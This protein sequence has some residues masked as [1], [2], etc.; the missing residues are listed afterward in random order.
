MVEETRNI[1]PPLEHT[2]EY[3]HIEE[4]IV[5][6]QDDAQDDDWCN[7][8]GVD[9]MNS[10]QSHEQ[11]KL[12]RHLK[13]ISITLD[14]Y[15][16]GSITITE[17]CN[18]VKRKYSYYKCTI[19]EDMMNGKSHTRTVV[20]IY[21]F[22]LMFLSAVLT[23][24]SVHQMYKVLIKDK[25][26][27]LSIITAIIYIFV[28][29][30]VYSVFTNTTEYIIYLNENAASNLYSSNKSYDIT[31]IEVSLEKIIKN[32]LKSKPDVEKWCAVFDNGNAQ[33][34]KTTS[35]TSP[36]M[37][38]MNKTDALSN[39]FNNQRDFISKG[40]NQN[41]TIIQNASLDECYDFFT[42]V[43]TKNKLME[44]I[45]VTDEEESLVY[46]NTMNIRSNAVRILKY[47]EG[48]KFRKLFMTLK[49]SEESQFY[50]L[51][52]VETLN[53]TL[54]NFRTNQ[55]DSFMIVS[56]I[57][58]KLYKLGLPEYYY[59]RKFIFGENDSSMGGNEQYPILM[60]SRNKI[61]V[62]HAKDIKQISD[63]IVDH[64]TEK[65]TSD[66]TY[67]FTIED[68]YLLQNPLYLE[69]ESIILDKIVYVIN[70]LVTTRLPTDFRTK[71]LVSFDL[72]NE[73][74]IYY[75]EQIT[76]N[77]SLILNYFTEKIKSDRHISNDHKFIFIHNIKKVIQ[78]AYAESKTAPKNSPLFMSDSAQVAPNNKYISFEDFNVKLIHLNKTHINSF[79]KV[80]KTA[81]DDL[82]YYMNNILNIDQGDETTKKKDGIYDNY[83]YLFS[84]ISGLVLINSVFSIYCN[85]NSIES[86]YMNDNP[87][88]DM[89]KVCVDKTFTSMTQ[90]SIHVSIWIVIVVLLNTYSI[91]RKTYAQYNSITMRKNTE[92]LRRQLNI[93]SIVLSGYQTAFNEPVSMESSN[94]PSVGILHKKKRLYAEFVKL[95]E[96]YGKCN[97]I[98]TKLQTQ[99]FP[100]GNILTS[101]F[102]LGIMCAIIYVTVTNRPSSTSFSFKKQTGGA[103]AMKTSTAPTRFLKSQ[104]QVMFDNISLSFSIIIISLYFSFQVFGS[105]MKIQHSLNSGKLYLNSKCL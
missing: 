36:V 89:S 49:I 17:A 27:V 44:H 57:L 24:Y 55:F 47:I 23:M 6:T 61:E 4:E 84:I 5:V 12:I 79:L 85:G 100:T 71:Y 82:K 21:K 63:R 77:S 16:K 31:N 29:N 104:E 95:I 18:T 102:L 103:A 69:S 70:S 35:T 101:V 2:D 66:A 48:H 3:D 10:L 34:E 88:F 19:K 37:V 26:A 56:D 39:F 62:E 7:N 52:C 13:D 80:V 43:N 22:S 74:L 14:D 91:N 67:V 11:Q 51:Y 45:N 15:L 46:D 28:F 53:N 65:T 97:H 50:D 58:S 96:I 75:C 9:E 83:I 59:L 73:V 54:K 98:R 33:E 93:F 76:S 20:F 64:L 72:I 87:E 60:K 32:D 25:D 78:S 8:N 68:Y 40:Q 42:G 38:N 30:P 81:K 92:D 1:N 94:V 90:S 41:I 86:F 99:P 105:S